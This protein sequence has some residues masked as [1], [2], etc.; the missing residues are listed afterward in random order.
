MEGDPG[1]P[2]H[3]AQ[4]VNHRD[5]L[6][7]QQLRTEPGTVSFDAKP[8]PVPS[9]C[10]QGL[11]PWPLAAPGLAATVTAIRSVVPQ[12][13]DSRGSQGRAAAYGSARAP[14][15]TATQELNSWPSG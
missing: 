10:G 12:M 7:L 5:L 6:Q 2:R 9:L 15:W 1:G 13:A 4:P 14:V 11:P 3:R 8:V